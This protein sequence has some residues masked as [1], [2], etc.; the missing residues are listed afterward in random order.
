MKSFPL[1]FICFLIASCSNSKTESSEKGIAH[2][3]V[4]TLKHEKGSA[5]AIEFLETANLAL[6]GID[7]VQDFT[8]RDQV[9]PKSN[10]Q[11]GFYMVF[12]DK[13]AY[14][15]YNN[16]PDHIKFVKEHW[17]K[18]VTDFQ[19]FDFKVIEVE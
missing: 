2:T 11:Y 5:S 3:V 14:S 17:E 16:H 12:E 7:V 19:E 6:T 1:L 13:E 15:T 18:Q 9:S 10:F 8:V 4:F